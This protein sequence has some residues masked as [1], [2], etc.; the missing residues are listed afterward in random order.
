M[1]QVNEL[2]KEIVKDYEKSRV[3][4]LKRT[5][6]GGAEAAMKKVKRI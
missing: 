3:N 6:V 4:R 1:E 2:A 5:F